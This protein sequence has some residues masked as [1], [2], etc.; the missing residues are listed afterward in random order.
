MKKSKLNLKQL[1]EKIDWVAIEP[2]RAQ[3]KLA[4]DAV[5]IGFVPHDKKKPEEIDCV[6]IR[7]GKE[8]IQRCKWDTGDQIVVMYDPDDAMS[9]LLCKTENG[10]GYKLG[11][12]S[13]SSI[14][15]LKF[16]WDRGIKLNYRKCANV[17]YEIHNNQIV[18]FRVGRQD[19]EA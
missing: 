17:D 5:A 4:D 2:Q 16:K 8:V 10:R 7:I 12:E 14:H 9:F 13:A 6:S 3:W 1:I 11:L 18:I 15:R 19:A